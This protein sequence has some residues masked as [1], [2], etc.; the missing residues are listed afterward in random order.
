M[1]DPQAFLGLPLNFKDICTIYPP[2]VK[3][4][5]ATPRATQFCKLLTYT[6]DD[7]DDLLEDAKKAK[8]EM[9][10]TNLTPFEFILINAYQN[11]TFREVIQ[12][13]FEFFIH[14]PVTFVYS[15]KLILIGDIPDLAKETDIT[16]FRYLSEDNFF[17]FQNMIRVSYGIAPVAFPAKDEEDDPIV[18]RVKQAARR[19]E[20]MANKSKKTGG[21]SLSTSLGAI[22]CMGIGLTPLNIGEISYASIDVLITLYQQK[23][24]YQADLESLWA[25]ADPKKVHPK[26]WIRDKSDFNEIKI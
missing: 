15:G 1:I 6:Q 7:I 10:D 14:E 22:C 20:R 2:K 11:E 26:Y 16:K 8:V 18:K 24:K 9:K 23:E 25:G 21:I 3:E 13:A 17:D 12:K 4:V 19:R 5:M